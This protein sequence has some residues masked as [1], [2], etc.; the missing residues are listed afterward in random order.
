MKDEAMI[1]T[2]NHGFSRMTIGGYHDF[3]GVLPLPEKRQRTAAVQDGG[4]S[5]SQSRNAVAQAVA[6]VRALPVVDCPTK[7]RFTPGLYV[8]EIFMPRGAVV[9]SKLHKTE[10]PFVISKGKCAVWDAGNGVQELAAPFCGVTKAGTQRVLLVLEDCVWTTFH[11]ILEGEA[12]NL[13]KIEARIIQPQSVE[14]MLRL[15]SESKLDSGQRALET[16]GSL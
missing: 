1:G 13:A 15:A 16:E 2:E 6:E 9:V 7:H 8:R 14:E 5:A 3:S 12:W 11:P 10:H 4:T